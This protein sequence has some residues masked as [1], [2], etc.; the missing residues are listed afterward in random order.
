MT[1]Y[2]NLAVLLLFLMPVVGFAQKKVKVKENKVVGKWMIAEMNGES[3]PAE[4]NMM[5]E[6]TKEG[7]L[8]ISMNDETLES[9]K[10]AVAEDQQGLTIQSE[11]R[12][13]ESWNI[14]ALSKTEM[15][16][17]DR[18]DRLVLRKEGAK[19]KKKKKKKGKV[20]SKKIVGRWKATSFNG[21]KLPEEIVIHL[22]L[23]KDGAMVMETMGE[24]ELEGTWKVDDTKTGIL[25]KSKE[26]DE[27]L[28]EVTKLSKDAL[29]IL[30][31]QVTIEL[32]RDDTK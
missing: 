4:M 29:D 26:G 31:G 3:L 12:E 24:T 23:S 7:E 13:D 19:A 1:M 9:A 8:K 25:V 32:V 14:D 20:K 15:V 18:E 11:D 28:W 5:I 10:W 16:I 21:E 27:E 2:R 22:E 6:F 17:I 30:S